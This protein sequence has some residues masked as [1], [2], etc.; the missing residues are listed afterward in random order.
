M[1]LKHDEI[2]KMA[3]LSKLYLDDEQIKNVTTDLSNI[4]ELVS[5]LND[6]DAKDIEPL[7]H[8]LEQS[9]PLRPDQATET[10]QREALQA[11]APNTF[12]GLYI[13]P[14]VIDQE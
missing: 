2:L 12:A 1:T 3:D 13:V 6:I 14:K 4:L 7:A 9:Q 5:K 11:I 8:P 10:N